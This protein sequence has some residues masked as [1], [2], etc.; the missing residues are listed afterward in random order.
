VA[1]GLLGYQLY[2]YIVR[3]KAKCKDERVLFFIFGIINAV[4]I[5]IH[6]AILPPI[7]RGYFYFVQEF[8]RFMTLGLVC[9]YYSSKA[10][11]LIPKK[12]QKILLIILK[13]VMIL[14]IPVY[15]AILV[16][17]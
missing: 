6:Y 1:I 17:L 15:I 13:T 16:F 10:S 12:S 8:G 14:S 11:G 5:L 3:H 9:Y 7:D 4:Y 2:V